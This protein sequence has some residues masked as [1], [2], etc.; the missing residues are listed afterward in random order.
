MNRAVSNK[1]VRIRPEEYARLKNLQKHFEAF[2]SYVSH[3]R[4]IQEAREDIERGDMI[5]QE[6]LFKSHGL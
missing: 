4:D 6:E 1:Y 2:W 3:L 5:S